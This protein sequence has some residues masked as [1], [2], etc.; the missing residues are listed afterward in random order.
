[1]LVDEDNDE[2]DEDEI[3]TQNMQKTENT[4]RQKTSFP[5]E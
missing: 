4:E 3:E 1:M 5:K 2:V